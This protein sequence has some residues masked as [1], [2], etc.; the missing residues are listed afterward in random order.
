M[1]TEYQPTVKPHHSRKVAEDKPKSSSDGVDVLRQQIDEM[2][3]REGTDKAA[4]GDNA[5]QELLARDRAA[6]DRLIAAPLPKRKIAK[7]YDSKASKQR[8]PKPEGDE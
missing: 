4:Y 5:L 3:A 6:T 7:K 8:R 2:L 1:P